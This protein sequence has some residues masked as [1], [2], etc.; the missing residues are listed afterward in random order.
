M[1]LELTLSS[2]VGIMK[3]ESTVLSILT[4][5]TLKST[6][7][8][9]LIVECDDKIFNFVTN[10]SSSIHFLSSTGSNNFKF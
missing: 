2:T 4:C 7:R 6:K 5:L 1:Y 9:T 10:F 8:W 3:L